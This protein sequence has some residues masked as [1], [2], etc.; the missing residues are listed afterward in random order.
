M[1]ALDQEHRELEIE[2]R[3]K[4]CT[5]QPLRSVKKPP[6]NGPMAGPWSVSYVVRF[7]KIRR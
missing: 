5:F 4:L 7:E 2:K 3:N 6:M 1:W